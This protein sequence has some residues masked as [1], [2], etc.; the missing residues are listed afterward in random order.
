MSDVGEADVASDDSTVGEKEE[1]MEGDEQTSDDAD[2]EDQ[3]ESGDGAAEVEAPAEEDAA[4]AEDTADNGNEAEESGSSDLGM[5]IMG[6]GDPTGQTITYEVMKGE[7]KASDAAEVEF[8]DNSV[9]ET[10]GKRTVKEAT[11]IKFTVKL[12]DEIVAADSLVTA[13]DGD[14]DIDASKIDVAAGEDGVY[15]VTITN[16]ADEAALSGDVKIIIHVADKKYTLTAPDAESN[17]T[18]LIK[19]KEAED[20][21]YAASVKV[22]KSDSVIVQATLAADKDPVEVTLNGTKKLLTAT[23]TEAAT[24]EFEFAAADLIDENGAPKPFETDYTVKKEVTYTVTADEGATV[25]IVDAAGET[26]EP[27]TPEDDS[28]TRDAKTDTY[29]LTSNETYLIKIAEVKE[30]ADLTKI[31]SVTVGGTAQRYNSVKNGFEFKAGEADSAIVVTCP[32]EKTA[33]SVTFDMDDDA[34]E[35][36]TVKADE[37]KTGAGDD[38]KQEADATAQPIG[39]SK[40]YAGVW[41]GADFSFALAAADDEFYEVTKVETSTDDENW[42]ELTE[43]DGKYTIKEISADTKVKVSTDFQKGKAYSITFT[44]DDDVESV[45]ADVTGTGATNPTEGVEV[46][47]TYRFKADENAKVTFKVETEAG[48][49]VAALTYGSE[50][51]DKIEVKDTDT[52]ATVYTFEGFDADNQAV[53]IDITTKADA[54]TENKYVTF[55]TGEGVTLK[56]NGVEPEQ[57]ENGEDVYVLTKAEEEVKDDEGNVT[58][59][60]VDEISELKFD[61]IVPYGSYLAD[62]SFAEDTNA[63]KVRAT[64]E[65]RV[66]SEDGKT[67]TYSYKVVAN[68]VA[69]GTSQENPEVITIQDAESE[70]VSL[71]YAPGSETVEYKILGGEYDYSELAKAGEEIPANET[72]I[73]QAQE[74]QSLKVDGETV[75]L[76]DSNR[77]RFDTKLDEEVEEE[78]GTEYVIEAK[79][80]AAY[81]ILYTVGAGTQQTAGDEAVNVEYD[82]T[83]TLKLVKV[84]G[85]AK[86]ISDK[87]LSADKSVFT[88]ADQTTKPGEATVTVKDADVTVTLYAIEET[89]VNGITVDTKVEAAKITFTCKDASGKTLTVKGIAKGKTV[90]L[91]ATSVTSYAL[92]LKDGSKTLNAAEY[93]KALKV[94]VDQSKVKVYIEDGKL[95][96]APIVAEEVPVKILAADG[97]ELYNFTVNGQTPALKVKSVTSTNQGMHDILVD[98]AADTSIK[99]ISDQFALYYEVKVESSATDNANQK[100]GVYYLDAEEYDAKGKF[101]PVSRLFKVNTETD[102]E[103]MENEYTFSVRLVAVAAAD[104]ATVTG[105]AGDPLTGTPG[106]QLVDKTEI[107]FATAEANIKSGKFKT[108]KGYYEDKLGVTKKTTKLYSGQQ[109]I[110]VAIPKFSKNASHIEDIKAV[111]YNKD[112]SLVD[113]TLVDARVDSETLG[114]YVDTYD[115]SAGTYDVVI[116]ATATKDGSAYDM[117]RAS[118]KVPITVQKGIDW[119]ELDYPIQIAV[120]G[121]DASI[122]LKATGWYEMNEYGSVV[123]AQT[124]KF[125]YELDTESIGNPKN[126]D[127]VI[128]KNNK[129]TVKKDFSVGAD[130]D[131]NTFIVEVKPNDYSDNYNVNYAYITVTNEA[132]EISSVRLVDSEGTDLPET[133]TTEQ[134]K[135]AQVVLAD[136]KG[137]EITDPDLVTLTPNKGKV[138]VYYGRD[139]DDWDETSAFRIGVNGYQKNLTIKATTTDGGKKSASSK[140]YTITYPDDIRY[141][142]KNYNYSKLTNLDSGAVLNQTGNTYTYIGRGNDTICFQVTA[143][144]G[145]G[146]DANERYAY[147]SLF[148]YSVKVT[149]GKITSTKSQQANGYYAITPNKDAVEITITDKTKKAPNNTTKFT[150]KDNGWTTTAAPSASTKGKLYAAKDESDWIKQD[151]TYTVK[152]KN[153][154]SYEAVKLNWVSGISIGGASGEH[155]IS[156]GTFTL[157]KAYSGSVGTA[158]YSAVYGNYEDDIFIPK[159]KAATL[160]IKV[161]KAANPKAVA[162]YTINPKVSMSAQLDVKPAL[163]GY[164]SR[165]TYK[166]VLSANNKGNKNQFYDYF[167]VVGDKLQIKADKWTQLDKLDAKTDLTGYLVYEYYDAATGRKV[168]K[169]DKITV[170]I[171]DKTA[172]KYTATNVDIVAVDKATAATTIKLGNTPVPIAKVAV[173]SDAWEA[174][175]PTPTADETTGVVNLT[176]KATPASGNVDLYV[177]PTASQ[178]GSVEKADPKTDGIKVTVKVTT[179]AADDNKTKITLAKG[180]KTP[181]ASINKTAS[182]VKVDLTVELKADRDFTYNL[183]NATIKTAEETKATLNGDNKAAADA[184]KSVALNS[185]KD[186]ITIVLDR[187]G[188]AGNKQYKVPVD[189][190]FTAGADETVYFPIKTEK[191]PTKEDV[192]KLVENA[193]KDFAVTKAN[194]NNAAGAAKE[195]EVAAKAIEIS[196]V[197]GIEVT[198]V[199]ADNADTFADKGETKGDHKIKITLKELTKENDTVDVVITVTEKVTEPTVGDALKEAIGKFVIPGDDGVPAGKIAV[200]KALESDDTIQTELQEAVDKVAKNKYIVKVDNIHVEVASV[201]AGADGNEGSEEEDN[202]PAA[203]DDAP[204]GKVTNLTFS[205]QVLKATTLEAMDSEKESYGVDLSGTIETPETTPDVPVTPGPGTEEKEVAT[206]EINTSDSTTVTAGTAAI[207]KF[208]ATLKA[209]DG[210]T[211]TDAEKIAAIEWTVAKDGGEKNDGT[212]I[213]ADSEN[214]ASATLTVAAAET[215]GTLTVTATV[216]GSSATETVKVEAEEGA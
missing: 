167:E 68:Q 54:L 125:L 163:A 208:T 155:G 80:A 85:T 6:V 165:V 22:K 58:T 176:A 99:T 151:L 108:R 3:D 171:S 132:L 135:K 198:A 213:V 216:K 19:E 77:Y 34:V 53:T 9:D 76:D 110:L 17:I 193:L 12:A 106:T 196:P 64:T 145:S 131:D 184:V 175:L 62:K 56:V 138:Y 45:T 44:A 124:Q 178:N 197:S 39:T 57:N 179:K 75:K 120:L 136:G 112:G 114:V 104:K 69:S 70:G 118:V 158:K 43:T 126:R 185:A 72:V 182:P 30:A 109:D 156:E 42:T 143:T 23:A 14:T 129:V 26:V 84:D 191:I 202:K 215:A 32:Q 113:S 200:T 140:K 157:N 164:E 190:T 166:G 170:T 211:I 50:E 188:L 115:Y 47:E 55:V 36:A 81:K 160:S 116:Y 162:K 117:Y 107:K 210:S 91:D 186:T 48:Y 204:E 214:K 29:K 18:W 52:A 102:N 203:A 89:T 8:I 123:K 173:D 150:F 79:S 195:V 134:L 16:G 146:D 15:T 10:D 1:S 159:T 13:K 148:N 168:E 121:K 127:K 139:W 212:T 11:N 82:D 122:T 189:L 5:E 83:V 187:D 86:A 35:A 177:I 27:E 2:A 194:Y 31:K 103:K 88:L 4:P 78:N 153:N 199:A 133:M 169:Q 207:V 51:S 142:I 209:T 147:T 60:A 87:E 201:D 90:K 180:V 149:G 74:G 105:K 33:F 97:N 98:V 71:I 174:A 206:I 49:K 46:G 192:K 25:S 92:T 96:V 154:V 38:D 40:V 20:T 61:L 183:S 119:V 137:K 172:P 28:V 95:F 7:T 141:D 21:T 205:Y 63:A 59:P 181:E 111:V 161:N 65:K 128:V 152:W 41:K 66:K 130:P 73:L 94:E 144:T 93:D 37:Y 100:E 24:E 101:L 67:W